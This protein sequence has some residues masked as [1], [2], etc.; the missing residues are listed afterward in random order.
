MA[1]EEG[2]TIILAPFEDI[3]TLRARATRAPLKI[4]GRDM[5]PLQDWSSLSLVSALFPPYR[6][7]RTI[8][9]GH[10]A[11]YS[12]ITHVPELPEG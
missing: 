6:P 7:R 4:G 10:P 5:S 9:V 3:G 8:T 1:T 2:Q 12:A 11:P